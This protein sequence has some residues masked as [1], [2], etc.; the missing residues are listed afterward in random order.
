MYSP[1]Y[2]KVSLSHLADV[3]KGFPNTVVNMQF[4]QE[5]KDALKILL[6]VEQGRYSRQD[7]GMILEELRYRFGDE[8]QFTIELVEQIEKENSGK[9]R[10]IKN[11]MG[12][13]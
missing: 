4:I 8:M 2:G 6:V 9:Y 5:A 12:I 11:L 3:I 10:L 7:E 1:A 13:L